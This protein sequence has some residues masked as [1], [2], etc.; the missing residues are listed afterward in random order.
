MT[1]WHWIAGGSLAA[2][3][4]AGALLLL[5]ARGDESAPPS[6]PPVAASTS[7]SPDFPAFADRVTADLQVR[8]DRRRVDLGSVRVDARFTP[9]RALGAPSRSQSG[10]GHSMIIRYRYVLN[11]LEHDC[12][13]QHGKTFLFP[14]A[15]VSYRG[16]ESGKVTA[17]WPG[18]VVAS[19]LQPTDIKRPQ[20][21]DGL[22]PLP[23]VSY[24]V[25]PAML[26]LGLGGAA[27]LLIL[28]A[29]GLVAAGRER[30]VLAAA[31]ETNG[32]RSP[33]EA[34]LALVRQAAAAGDP[35]MQR[36]ALERLAAELR[37]ARLLKL[38]RSAR[39]LAWAEPLPQRQATEELADEVVRTVRSGR[40]MLTARRRPA[41]PLADASSFERQTRRTT[42]SRLVL[43]ALLAAL[44]VAAFLLA[45][46]LTQRPNI[47]AKPH[48]GGVL[49]LDLSTSVGP[50][51][52]TLIRSTLA[53]LT[54]QR[55]RLGVVIFSDSAYEVLPPDTA[56]VE[57]GPIARF[58]QPHAVPST[59]RPFPPRLIENP[60]FY[61]NPW[62]S[63]YHGGTQIS[64]GL[65]LA[66]RILERD[67]IEHGRVILVSD[68]T[69]SSLDQPRLTQTVMRYAQKGI[70]LEVVDLSVG[71][72]DRRFYSQLTG[73][74]VTLTLQ[75]PVPVTVSGRS[76][77][78]LVGMALALILLLAANEY[79]CRRLSW[80]TV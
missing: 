75:P 12:L 70:R 30:P 76:P 64:Q 9:Y 38:A 5:L 7:I 15:Q 17:D 79:W 54:A 46:D 69:E 8:V 43:A 53:K 33:L 58:F 47:G 29:S 39:R 22:R 14:K 78:W 44:A 19:R 6:G 3:L 2:A 74:P 49:V 36:K 42:V 45:R 77:A 60:R 61:D 48:A 25:S 50:S 63:S 57:L 37:R 31:P 11:C 13:P 62:T 51:T 68:L 1:R 26:G 28:T 41:I 34:A 40:L 23:A 21:R 32:S 4:A 80:R 52:Y 55:E 56:P 27:V 24:R 35:V 59:P 10:S 67:G 73:Q 16:K 66:E 65:G 20:L 72:S 18:L 71:G